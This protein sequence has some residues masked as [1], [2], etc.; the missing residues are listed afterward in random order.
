MALNEG[1]RLLV[2]PKHVS[3][4]SHLAELRRVAVVSSRGDSIVPPMRGIPEI[5]DTDLHPKI[6]L[7]ECGVMEHPIVAQHPGRNCGD[8]GE[9]GGC[10]RHLPVSSV[11]MQSIANPT[12]EKRH[13]G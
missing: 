13:N 1:K 12:A 7:Q 4:V 9:H 6:I 10:R 11:A 3:A 2:F 5:A 8:Y